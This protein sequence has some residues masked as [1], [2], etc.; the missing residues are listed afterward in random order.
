MTSCFP[1]FEKETVMQIA[2]YA[3]KNCQE[4]EFSHFKQR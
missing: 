2:Y 1:R 4:R 3:E